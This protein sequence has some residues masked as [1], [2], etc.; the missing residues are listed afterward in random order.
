MKRLPPIPKFIGSQLGPVPIV[1]VTGLK[2]GDG[3]DAL[4]LWCP[5]ERCIKLCAGIHRTTAWVTLEHEK[6]HMLLWDAG[7]NLGGEAEERV[8]DAIASARVAEMLR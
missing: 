6:I 5:E 2:A 7:T 8:A 3:D 1:W 4:G